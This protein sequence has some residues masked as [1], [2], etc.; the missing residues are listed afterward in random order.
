MAELTMRARR[1]ITGLGL[2]LLAGLSVSALGGCG[3][4]AETAEKP[5]PPPRLTKAQLGE[6]MGDICQEHTDLQVVEIE[7][8]EKK[9]GL[10]ASS[11][12]EVPAAQLEKELTVVIL[13]IVRD[14]IRDLRRELRPPKAQEETFE[15]FLGAL[16]HGV[17]YSE[18]DPTWLPTGSQEPFHNAR[19]LAWELGTA[20]CGQA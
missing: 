6:R 3:E 11:Q 10:P 15:E 20:Y 17:S 2:V 5:P 9:H 8:F 18:K 14:T 13:P 19:A 7:R 4:S 1:T 12:E 16:E